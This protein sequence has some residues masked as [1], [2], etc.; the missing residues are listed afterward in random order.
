[1]SDAPIEIEAGVR[2]RLARESVVWLTTV[3]ATGEPA[4]TPVWF[5]WADG[6]VWIRTK[7]PGAKLAHIAANPHVALNLNSDAAGNQVVVL[8]GT[9]TVE[10]TMPEAVWG[11]YV[12]KYEAQMRGLDLTPETF[13]A[14]YVVPIRVRVERVRS[15]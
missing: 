9:A 8:N 7:P 6:D 13:E 15:W 5:V 3:R 11:V 1:M 2:E 14:S 12:R 4:P 10:Q